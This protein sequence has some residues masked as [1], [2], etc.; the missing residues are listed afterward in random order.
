MRQNL[1]KNRVLFLFCYPVLTHGATN[2]TLLRSFHKISRTIV[3]GYRCFPPTEL[4]PPL[5]PPS[6]GGELYSVQINLIC[7]LP[8]LCFCNSN[9]STWER[10]ARAT[11]ATAHFTSFRDYAPNGAVTPSNSPCNRGRILFCANQFD[12][13]PPHFVL[14]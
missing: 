12:L 11:I 13:R 3:R 8:T 4:S 1:R 7:V 5:A 14:L 6:T 10:A 2:I 9:P